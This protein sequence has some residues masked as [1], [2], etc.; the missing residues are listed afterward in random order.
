MALPPWLFGEEGKRWSPLR[1]KQRPHDRNQ[2]AA[3]IGV[4]FVVFTG[5]LAWSSRSAHE[6]RRD[7]SAALLEV[8]RSSPV[9]T[10]ECDPAHRLKTLTAVRN[11]SSMPI[12]NWGWE[13]TRGVHDC[14]GDAVARLEQSYRERPST[15]D[16]LDFMPCD[17]W[18][19]MENR[20]LWIVGDRCAGCGDHGCD[21][22]TVHSGTHTMAH[23]GD[24]PCRVPLC[25][26]GGRLR[27]ARRLVLVPVCVGNR[28]GKP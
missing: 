20:T 22:E 26:T 9:L 21:T 8:I 3:L 24:A 13:A 25:R 28:D 1:R 5:L 14:P 23:L 2:K 27:L 18:R 19:L 17:L 12:F 11:G 15:A 6:R 7:P 16:M 4:V 10:A